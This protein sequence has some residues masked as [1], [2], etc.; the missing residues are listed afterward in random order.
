MSQVV[1][2]HVGP[3]GPSINTINTVGPD[4][5]GNLTL[6]G[7]GP[8]SVT[9]TAP[10]TLT[11]S[12]SGSGF[13][14]STITN[15]APVVLATGNVG[16]TTNVVG[17]VFK[18]DI[19]L[20]AVAAAGDIVEVAGAPGSTGW[21]LR[22]AAGQRIYLDNQFT[23]VAGYMESNNVTTYITVKCIVAN[24]TWSVRSISGSVGIF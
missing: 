17:G 23:N 8:I 9:N 4:A 14:W 6:V 11:I 5:G 16:F 13:T 22:A 15:P 2:L 12:F 7:S 18:A 3:T 1:T 24:T 10:N 19:T 20:P 21:I